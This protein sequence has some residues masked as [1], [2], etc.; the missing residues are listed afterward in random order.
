MG[1]IQMSNRKTVDAIKLVNKNNRLSL[2]RGGY[3]LLE[4]I[5]AM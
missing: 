1:K 5:S 4:N 2:V 3:F